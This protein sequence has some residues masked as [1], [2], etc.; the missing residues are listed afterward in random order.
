M[1]I[2]AVILVDRLGR[3]VLLLVSEIFMII[4]MAALG[5]FFYL[6]DN[7]PDTLDSI[8]WLPLV[9]LMLFIAA[10]AIGLGPMP[11]LMTSEIVPQKVKGPATSIATFINWMLAFIATKTFVD[12]KKGL[13]DAGAFWFFGAICVLG[14]FFCFF[15]VPET[16]GK[17][18]EEIQLFFGNRP[19]AP[20]S[21]KRE[22]QD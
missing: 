14:L 18:S 1:T 10:F 22:D 6:K 7:Q 17:T 11:W 20:V 2:L 13:T 5:T 4:S 15:A 16:A 8:G 19:A 12:L 21:D 9:S 3:K